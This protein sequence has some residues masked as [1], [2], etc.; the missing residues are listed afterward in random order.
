META[1]MKIAADA[2]L[3]HRCEIGKLGPD[4][5]ILWKTG[6]SRQSDMHCDIIHSTKTIRRD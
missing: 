1:E 2:D 5:I 3:V 6:Y 4:A